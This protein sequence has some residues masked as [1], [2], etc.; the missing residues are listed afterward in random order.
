MGG[1]TVTPGAGAIEGNYGLTY[2]GTTTGGTFR[3]TNGQNVYTASLPSSVSNGLASS[4]NA[5][6]TFSDGTQI[7]AAAFNG[8]A[9]GTSQEVFHFSKGTGINFSFQTGQGATDTIG[10]NF[11]G[12]SSTTLGLAGLSVTSKSNAQSAQNLIST[13]QSIINNQIAQLGGIKSELNYTGANL[14]VSIQNQSAARA[15]F[16]DADVSKSLIDSQQAKALLDAATATFQQ[17][18]QRQAELAQL[19]QQVLR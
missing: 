3:L 16:T 19:I 18:L 14:E 17:T 13:A 9:P 7:T 1:L 5:T 10:I 15:T 8:S 6:I 11:A 12:A 2:T 4:I